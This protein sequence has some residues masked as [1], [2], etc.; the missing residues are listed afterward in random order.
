[1]TAKKSEVVV[2]PVT[3]DADPVFAGLNL[4]GLRAMNSLS[5][6]KLT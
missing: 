1:M 3:L 6:G 4:V 5:G 2:S